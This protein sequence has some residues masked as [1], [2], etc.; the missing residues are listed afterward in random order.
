[1]FEDARYDRLKYVILRKLHRKAMWGGTYRPFEV[2]IS[3]I[4]SH[5]K[6]FAKDVAND[7]IKK[8][9]LLSHKGGHA[10]SLNPGRKQE[11]EDFIKKHAFLDFKP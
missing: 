2:A 6:G 8:E 1:M 5:E 4:P 10:V 9:W 3:G 11:I 7:L